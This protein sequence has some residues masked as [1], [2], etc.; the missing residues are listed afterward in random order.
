M[1]EMSVEAQD[2]YPADVMVD[3]MGGSP[4]TITDVTIQPRGAVRVD[5]RG[6]HM[7]EYFRRSDRIQ[8]IRADVPEPSEIE[9]EVQD[10]RYLDFVIERGLTISRVFSEAGGA[11]RMD[12][13][14]DGD[15]PVWCRRADRVRIIRPTK[16]I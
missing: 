15:H 14:E 7:E 12:F 10:L 16:L 3:Y 9:V 1:A 8:I 5:F 6:D 2:L 4:R 13:L 11:V